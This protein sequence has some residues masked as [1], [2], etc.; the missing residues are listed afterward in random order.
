MKEIK[1]FQAEDGIVFP[2]KR[3]AAAHEL[4]LFLKDW[5]KKWKINF[6]SEND[7]ECFL[8]A[9]LNEPMDMSHHLAVYGTICSRKGLKDAS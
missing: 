7:E 2:Q 1:A 9:L 4:L 3:D 8:D 6:E 5:I